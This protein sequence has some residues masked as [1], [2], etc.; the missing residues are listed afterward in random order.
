M[1]DK[2]HMHGDGESDSG[3]VPAKQPNKSGQPPA[4]AVEGRPLT[5]EN[6]DQPN[7]YR[8]QKR[9]SW[10]SKL[11]H[12]REAAKKDKKLKF[13]ALLHH[14]TVDLLRDSYGALK[15]GAAP[16]VDGVTWQEY[17]E[18]LEERLRKPPWSHPSPGLSSVT[19]TENLDTQS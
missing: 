3:V 17:G 4:E 6:M 14:V 16:G 5:K 19:V 8:T 18:D 12:V 7:Q 2:T 10:S 15:R 1:S 11:A 9:K 13:T